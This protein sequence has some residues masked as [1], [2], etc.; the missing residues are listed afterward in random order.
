MNLHGFFHD[1]INLQNLVI[2][3]TIIVNRMK[4]V[5]S[6]LTI[7][8]ILCRFFSLFKFDCI[9]KHN[10]SQSVAPVKMDIW[11]LDKIRQNTSIKMNNSKFVWRTKMSKSTS[12]AHFYLIHCKKKKPIESNN[13][14]SMKFSVNFSPIIFWISSFV[15][16]DRY[17]WEA[18]HDSIDV[19]IDFDFGW[20][21][22]FCFF[23]SWISLDFFA[24][25]H[26]STYNRWTI[27]IEKKKIISGATQK[28]CV[29]CDLF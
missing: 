23:R 4:S 19:D 29:V 17:T 21:L 27:Q 15:T 16:L 26:V 3:N 11:H 22:T 6:P 18:R 9:F 25:H 7:F 10:R 5:T 8:G 28:P 14:K 13:K 2:A 20:R 24:L 1:E 12:V